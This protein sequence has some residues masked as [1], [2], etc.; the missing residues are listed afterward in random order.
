MTVFINW[1]FPALGSS[2]SR[3][4]PERLSDIVNVKDWGALGDNSHND[5]PNIQAAIDYCLNTDSHMTTISSSDS[6]ITSAY[7][8]CVISS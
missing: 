8:L 5:S 2:T 6:P 1:P 4:L 7:L 3:T